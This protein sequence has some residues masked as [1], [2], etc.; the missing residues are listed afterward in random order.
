MDDSRS[1]V[2]GVS[3]R[4]RQDLSLTLSS[5]HSCAGAIARYERDQC[6]LNQEIAASRLQPYNVNYSGSSGGWKWKQLWTRSV[7]KYGFRYMTL[8]SDGDANTH[9]HLRSLKNYGDTPI[10]KEE[11]TNHVAKRL[12]TALNRMQEEGCHSWWSWLRQVDR[13][14]DHQVHGLLREGHPSPSSTVHRWHPPEACH[15]LTRRKPPSTMI[16]P[17]IMLQMHPSP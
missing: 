15:G 1:T 14:R 17:L 4:S 10:E 5:C 12:G 7:D 11:C 3:P 2:L 6:V 8:L 13:F 16:Q 9:S